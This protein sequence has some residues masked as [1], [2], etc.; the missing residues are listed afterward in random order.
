MPGSWRR[1]P[2]GRSG[3]LLA[4]WL[5]SS[6]AR[7][8][9][10]PRRAC[11]PVAR[12]PTCSARRTARSAGWK[13]RAFETRAHAWHRLHA[14]QRDRH[15]ARHAGFGSRRRSSR[16]A[17][18]VLHRAFSK[19]RASAAGNGPMG[20]HLGTGA[21]RPES[22]TGEC[23]SRLTVLVEQDRI[24]VRIGDAEARRPAGAVDRLCRRRGRPPAT[25]AGLP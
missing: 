16:R 15:R 4:Q 6:R 1:C 20:Q 17:A 13:A 24:A 2:A 22:R 3:R 25:A 5:W 19:R 9:G 8:Q 10:R 18:F 21:V 14:R 12:R 23:P 11:C 7:R